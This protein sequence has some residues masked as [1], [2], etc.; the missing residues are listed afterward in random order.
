L[1][2]ADGTGGGYLC[3][4]FKDL[5]LRAVLEHQLRLEGLEH[6]E[7]GLG[8]VSAHGESNTWVDPLHCRE[9]VLVGRY[10]FCDVFSLTLSDQHTLAGAGR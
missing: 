2:F 1:E 7:D 6:V 3:H 5:D 10:R 8:A 4:G 9:E